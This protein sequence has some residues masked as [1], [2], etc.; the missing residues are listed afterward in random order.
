MV[1]RVAVEKIFAGNMLMGVG[2]VLGLV[3]VAVVAMEVEA[4]V[5]GMVVAVAAGEQYGWQPTI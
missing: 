5:A 4:E 3:A 2:R 1:A